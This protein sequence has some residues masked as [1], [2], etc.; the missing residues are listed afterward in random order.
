MTISPEG[1]TPEAP[2]G[3]RPHR[4]AWPLRPLPVHPFLLAAYLILFLFAENLSEVTLGEVLPPLG[5]ALIAV[6]TALLLAGVLLRDLRRGAIVA[7]GLVVGWYGYGHVADLVAPWGLSRDVILAG[8]AIFLVLAL[9]AA[10]LLSGRWIGRLTSAFDVLGGVLV[11]LAALRIFRFGSAGAGASIGPTATPRAGTGA[12]AAGGRDIYYLILDRYGS[13]PALDD[14]GA[15]EDGLP[16]W[17]A[18]QG[19]HV[20]RNAHANYGRTVLSVAAT[21]NMAPLDDI[22]ASMGPGSNDPAPVDRLIQSHAL[23]RFLDT[24]GYRYVHLGSWFAPTR[25]VGF[26]DENAMSGQP[27][28]FEA[29]LTKTTF[30]PT[31]DDLRGEFKPP[32]HHVLHRTTALFQ[33]RELERIRQEPGPKLVIAHVLLPH[34]PYVFDRYGD[35]PTPEEQAA[36]PEPEAYREQTLYLNDRVMDL[37]SELL[38]APEASRPI[39]VIQGDEGPWPARYTADKKRFDW[40]TATT[41]ELETK[42]GILAAM[43]LP[44]EAPAGAPGPYDTMS[45]W[46]TWRIV[47]RRYFGTDHELLPDRSYT[48][49]G[50][51]YP[52]DLTDVTHLLPAPYGQ[53]AEA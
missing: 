3:T 6:A 1:S 41:A 29:M 17:L 9:V 24:Q 51:D 43:Y 33:F 35:Y 20:A 37:V 8:W 32:T 30:G 10:I 38:S 23:G 52:Y 48:S 39:I 40:T 18:A 34:E 26:A 53:V 7:S 28:D 13:Q 12:G 42:Y 27:T 4:A 2:V 50:W 36:R 46:N 44:G 22:A 45:S 11:V 16:D 31:L 19:F 5:R 15:G 49:R 47:L 25:L 14:L 21:L